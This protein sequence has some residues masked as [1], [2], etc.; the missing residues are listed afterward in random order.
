M[1]AALV[2]LAIVAGVV[3]L[4]AIVVFL[5]SDDDSGE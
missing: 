2:A 3:G 1:E 4:A 5:F